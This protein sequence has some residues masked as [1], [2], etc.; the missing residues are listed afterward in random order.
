MAKKSAIGRAMGSRRGRCAGA[1][2]ICALLTTLVPL[3]PADSQA[4]TIRVDAT[5]SQV[6]NSF[7]PPHALGS[8]V[9]RVPSNATDPFFKPEAIQKILSAG[10][11]AISY[12]QNT[13]LFIQAWHWNPKGNCRRNGS[14]I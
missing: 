6:V 9:D 1:L 10:W 4:Q 3:W 11:G 2:R 12:R 8:T 14:R 7:S 5:P 13:D